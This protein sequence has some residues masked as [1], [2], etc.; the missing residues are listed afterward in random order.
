[1]R[2]TIIN[3][4]VL[5]SVPFILK[6]NLV[7]AGCCTKKVRCIPTFLIKF[8]LNNKTDW[9]RWWILGLETPGTEPTV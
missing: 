6:T 7:L 5:I 9:T 1:M 3:K 4:I 2:V 8:I